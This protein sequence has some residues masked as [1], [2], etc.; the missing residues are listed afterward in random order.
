MSIWEK[1]LFEGRS[2][3]NG[4]IRVSENFGV[5][6]LIAGANTQSQTLNSKGKTGHRYWD[7][8]VPANVHLGPDSRS[9]ILGL[10]GGTTAQII[11]RKF[12]PVAIDGVDIDPLMVEIGHKFLGM[13]LP[14]LNIIIEDA[15]HFIEDARYKYDLICVD[16]FV[17]GDVPKEIESEKFFSSVKKS[18]LP[19]G[20]CS[21]N[22]IFSGKQEMVVFENLV[23]KVFPDV[24]SHVV[25]GD[26]TLDNV[27]V[28]ARH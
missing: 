23:R 20:L 3:F 25:R 9:L 12:G 28:Y 24:R 22:K 1:I 21:I 26:P 13:D 4:E 14:N 8:M 17:A 2:K 19:A 7:D 11:T 18:L 27:I 16:V 5:R 10:G 6:R 15:A